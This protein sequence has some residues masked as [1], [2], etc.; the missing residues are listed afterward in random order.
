[1]TALAEAKDV[2]TA[3]RMRQALYRHFINGW[4]PLFEIS[5]D[6][7]GD[8]ITTANGRPALVPTFRRIDMLAVRRA[9]KTGIGPLDLLAVEIKVSRSDFL[10]DVRDPARQARWREVAHRHAYAAPKGLVRREEIPDGSGLLEITE[11]GGCGYVVEWTQRAP[12][13]TAPDVPAWLTLT[14][15]HRLARAEA[16]TRGLAGDTADTDVAELRARVKRLTR[17]L[18]NAERRGERMEQRADA[19]QRAFAEGNPVPCATCGHSIRPNRATLRG[20]TW[21]HRDK[22]TEEACVEKRI[23]AMHPHDR[24][25]ITESRRQHGAYGLYGVPPVEPADE[26]PGGA[27]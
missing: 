2:W 17:E 27:A 4:A 19:W 22:T 13:T 3:H 24:E 11:T 15:A 20:L 10:A 8:G 23:A 6:A 7:Q 16:L 9:R 25:R 12:Y 1:M 5:S 14:A 21:K 26:W 18:D